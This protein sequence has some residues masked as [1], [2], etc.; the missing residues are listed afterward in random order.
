MRARQ[1][2]IAIQQETMRCMIK[3]KFGFKI[4]EA[5]IEE[6][7]NKG[8]EINRTLCV[9]DDTNTLYLNDID[10]EDIIT[11]D[12]SSQLHGYQTLEYV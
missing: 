9:N 6:K 3:T 8:Y 10:A 11:S 2:K 1:V 5:E 7:N 4:T 12:K